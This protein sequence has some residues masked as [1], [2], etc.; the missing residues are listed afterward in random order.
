VGLLMEVPTT[1]T[2]CTQQFWA[3]TSPPAQPDGSQFSVRA[4]LLR[5]WGKFPS[6][7]GIITANL[8]LAKAQIPR[9]S[10]GL[11]GPIAAGARPRSHQHGNLETHRR[12]I[13]PGFSIQSQGQD[14]SAA[15]ACER[16]GVV[17]GEAHVGSLWTTPG[18]SKHGWVSKERAPSVRPGLFGISH[19][20]TSGCQ[21]QC[22]RYHP[23]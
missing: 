11:L 13:V 20:F 16:L 22:V 12:A 15:I 17:G 1:N 8:E 2:N 23:P 4:S 21:C 3:Q 6:R 18:L 10:P 7:W 19:I 14:A 5:C 9:G